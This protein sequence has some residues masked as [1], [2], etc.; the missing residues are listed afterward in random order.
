MKARIVLASLIVLYLL[1]ACVSF[2]AAYPAPALPTPTPVP[3]TDVIDGWQ[4]YTNPLGFSISYPAT[5]S[6]EE[7]P[8]QAGETIH[9]VTLQGAE[10]EVDLQW[11]VGFGGACPQGY[12]DGQGGGG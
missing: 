8:Q 12:H 3:A 6:Q 7:L 1:A 4:T 9:T 11:G 10:G 2:P 5:W